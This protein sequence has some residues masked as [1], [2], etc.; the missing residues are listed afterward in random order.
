[1]NGNTMSNISTTSYTRPSGDFASTTIPNLALWLD[2]SDTATVT[3]TTS[4]TNWSDKSGSG[5]NLTNATGTTSYLTFGIGRA[6]YLNSSYL[7]NSTPI[8]LSSC[9]VFILATTA[10]NTLNNQSLLSARATGALSADY[11]STDGFAMFLDAGSSN[12]RFYGQNSSGQFIT[13]SSVSTATPQIYSFTAATS[14]ALA[15]W[16]NGSVGGTATMATRT[17]T[18]Q[19]FF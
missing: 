6:I 15:S 9:S 7:L 12:T 13:N 3:G 16:R 10:N 8:D 18:A 14:G 19:G 4:V 17:N 1:M 5:R 2:A 11:N